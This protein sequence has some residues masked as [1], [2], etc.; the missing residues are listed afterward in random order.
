MTPQALLS[1]LLAIA[2]EA[3]RHIAAI[4]QQG[5]INPQLKA[6]HTPV[7]NADLAAHRLLCE[8]LQAL[9]P[10]IPVL[11]EE[12][13]QIALAERVAWPRYWLIDPLD[14]TQ[15]FIYGSGE[16]S[17]MIALMDNH[18]P[19]MG[20]IYAPMTQ[21]WYY[22]VQ[23]QGAYKR[24]QHGQETRLQIRAT[25]PDSHSL[26]VAVSRRQSLPRLQQQLNPQWNYQFVPYG[27]SSLKSCMV[28]EGL[29]DCYLRLGPTGEWD[30]A[31]AQC[32]LHEAGG[33]LR[34]LHL[35]ALTYN[36][37]DTLENP[38]FISFGNPALP[39]KTI[40]TNC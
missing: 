29:V 38:D 31:A 30:T 16:F 3:G 1:P 24:D 33:D 20:V 35:E 15:E 37:R 4:Y 28:A 21:M 9:T 23:G 22:A 27:S 11:S 25:A 10:Q 13:C 7:T 40:L 34:D 36:R 26:R 2:E 5:N 12:D 19:V 39:W 14:G 8:R 18:Q 17:T 32:I 6:D